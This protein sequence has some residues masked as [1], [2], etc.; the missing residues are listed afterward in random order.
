M[1]KFWEQVSRKLK[2]CKEAC[3]FAVN[4]GTDQEAYFL[5][6]QQEAEPKSVT[7]TD[8]SHMNLPAAFVR[9]HI[10]FYGSV[11]GVGFRYFAVYR[12]RQLNL[13]GW[14]RNL[15]NGSVEME[16][17]GKEERIEELIRFLQ[18]QQS[19]LIEKMETEIIP[20]I[21]ERNFRE[22]G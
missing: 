9:K 18:N 16:V 5:S 11:Q 1:G 22:R 3:G 13:T 14:V 19:I 4:Q 15:Y 10:I 17:Q 7:I 12:A 8:N 20:I 2:E 21:A 6:G